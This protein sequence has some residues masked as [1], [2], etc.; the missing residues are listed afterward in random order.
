V[1]PSVADIM[2]PERVSRTSFSVTL[3][4]LEWQ[5]I[6]HCAIQNCLTGAYNRTGTHNR[7]VPGYGFSRIE[8]K[9]VR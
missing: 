4:L 7:F 2:L 9:S 6:D 3:L 5:A 8:R 1:R